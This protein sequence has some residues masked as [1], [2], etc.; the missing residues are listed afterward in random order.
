MDRLGLDT[1][2]VSAM[3]NIRYY[4]GFSGSDGLLVLTHHDCWLLVDGRYVTQAREQAPECEVICYR[5]KTDAVR[6]LVLESA[7]HRIGFESERMTF[8]THAELVA[9]MPGVDFVPVSSELDALRQCKDATERTLLA[10]TA[11]LASAALVETLSCVQPGTRESDVALALEVAMKR[12]GAEACAFDFI[13]ASGERGALPHGRASHKLIAAGELVTIDYGAVCSGY[14]SDETVTIAVGSV[15][16]RQREIYEAVREAHD[17]AI[18]ATRP[19][20]PLADLDA[21]ARNH[22]AS[23]GFGD[24]FSHGLGHGVGL[25]IHEKPAV[26]ATSTALAEDGMVITIE[27]GIYIP[28]LGGVRI[29]DT[30]IV[31][32]SGCELL[33]QVNKELTVVAA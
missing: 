32:A 27:P 4:T 28:G 14:F 22:I 1:L 13:V 29:E 6:S 20:V 15:D 21:I 18:A 8:A 2:L 26:N 3:P 23:R 31:T 19:G 30:V 7:L 12:A 9:E 25:E 16:A 11:K 5:K 17:L 10:A 24:Y 33:T